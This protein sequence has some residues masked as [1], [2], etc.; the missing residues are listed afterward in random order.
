M[1]IFG[2]TFGLLFGLALIA[3]LGWAAWLGLE[4]IGALFATLDAQVAKVTAI[5]SAVVLAAAAIVASA[6][7]KGGANSEAARIREQKLGVYQFFVECWQGETLPQKLQV[8]DRLLALHGGAAVIKAHLALR[9]IAREKGV[10][11]P[12]TLSRLGS[13]LLEIRRELGSDAAARGI[14]A[15]DLGQLVLASQVPSGAH[16]GGG[17]SA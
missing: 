9:A 5:G 13:A 17:H 12:D 2:K 10:R 3:V 6:L 7:R 16:A 11:H 15:A 4:S 14:G 8:L 1:N